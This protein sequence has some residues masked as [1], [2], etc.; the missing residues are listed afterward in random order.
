MFPLPPVR[1]ITFGDRVIELN[2]VLPATHA[3]TAMEKVLNAGATIAEIRYELLAMA[4][5]TVVYFVIG[6]TLFTRRHMRA[7]T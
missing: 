2:E 3:I 1:L 4:V 7:R 5:L 6:V